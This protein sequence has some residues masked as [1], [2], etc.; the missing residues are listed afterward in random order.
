MRAV[1]V[2]RYLAAALLCTSASCVGILSSRDTSSNP[3]SEPPRSWPSAIQFVFDD[4]ASGRVHHTTRIQFHDGRAVREVTNRDL[5]R[6][7]QGRVVI[8][9]WYR[10]VPPSAGPL[11]VRV[12]LEHRD[13]SRTEADYP[14]PVRRDLFY[15]VFAAVTK[16]DPNSPPWIGMPMEERGYPLHPGA[17]AQA[18]DS[19]WIAFRV[20]SRDCYGCPR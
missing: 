16:R 13:G 20:H 14:L 1:G 2:I 11:N 19:L 8:T 4:T 15:E 3:E 5:V 18:G 7:H 17:A 9:P 6:A 10:L 12:L